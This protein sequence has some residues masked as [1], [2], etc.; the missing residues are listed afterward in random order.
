MCA[1]VPL[2][3]DTLLRPELRGADYIRP[4]SSYSS[5][6]TG[7]LRGSLGLL[8]SGRVLS[9]APL[10]PGREGWQIDPHRRRWMLEARQQGP[11]QPLVESPPHTLL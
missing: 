5:S 11:A 2:D 4:L 9:P 10:P 8:C 1:Q 6:G 3:A 7:M